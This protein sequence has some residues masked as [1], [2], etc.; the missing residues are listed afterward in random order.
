[1][2]KM[3]NNNKKQLLLILDITVTPKQTLDVI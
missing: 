1:M 3:N 2:P